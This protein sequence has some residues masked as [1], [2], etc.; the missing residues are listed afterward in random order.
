MDTTYQTLFAELQ[1]EAFVYWVS[2]VMG[3]SGLENDPYLHG[4]GLHSTKKLDMHLDYSIHPISGKQRRVNL[5]LF[6]NM[7]WEESWDGA[8]VL[9]PSDPKTKRMI[10]AT[11]TRIFPKFNRAV[12]F[13]TSSISWHGV[14]YTSPISTP[15]QTLAVYYV[16]E[17]DGS[18]D[19]R[20]K[21][22]YARMPG[23]EDDYDHLRAIRAMRRLEPSD[24]R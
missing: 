3:I 20:Y 23:Q 8:L 13:E 12:L 16:S 17:P 22:E 21:A 1:S 9:F 11:P 6:L 5:I 24:F 18:E 4:A 15:R 7:Q 14:P 10:Q 2:K 19:I